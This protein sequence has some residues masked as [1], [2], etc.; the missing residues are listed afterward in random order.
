MFGKDV[1]PIGAYAAATAGMAASGLE[2]SGEMAFVDT[3]YHFPIT[4]MV[5]PAEALECQD[6]HS[7]DGRMTK[8]AG[9]YIPGV[10]MPLVNSQYLWWLVALTVLAAAI[11]GLL[12][13]FSRHP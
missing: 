13:L 12:R 5:A 7:K 8:I 1:L 3:D 11:H 2:F 4:H 9:F 6:C 10:M